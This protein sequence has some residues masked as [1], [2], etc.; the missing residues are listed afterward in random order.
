M[1]KTTLI[2][3]LLIVILIPLTLYLGT[4]LTGRWYYLTSTLIIVET[5]VPFFLL[6]EARKPQARELVTIA[7]MAALAVASRVVILIPNFKPITAIIMV[8]G[9]AFGP[10]AG[11]MTGAI[12]AFASNFFFSQGPWTPWQM[13]A[14]GF[15]GFLAG[16]V[17]HHRKHRSP[18]ILAVFGF[19]TILFCVGPLLDTC[20]VFT[21]NTTITW[22]RTLL[23]YG[24]GFPNNFSHALA[25][26]AT[27]LLLGKPLLY[28]LD[29]LKTKYGM[30]DFREVP[31]GRK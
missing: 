5:M 7:V 9:I 25:C 22:K 3:L 26:G 6:F 31:H 16:L 11:F 18:V 21:V 15:G 12:S 2:N 23:I 28:K 13:M 10:E 14:Y 27:M 17:F 30:L 1:K 4:H 8:T 19:L 20:T 24:A 29:R